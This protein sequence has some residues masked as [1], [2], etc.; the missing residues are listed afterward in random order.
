MRCGR[1]SSGPHYVPGLGTKARAADLMVT[2]QS[3][4]VYSMLTDDLGWS[5]EAYE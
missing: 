5:S 1:R 4:Y 3:P 2:I